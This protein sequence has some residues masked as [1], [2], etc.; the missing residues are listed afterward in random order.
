[1]SLFSNPV[2]DTP[3]YS[4]KYEVTYT[5]L[6]NFPDSTASITVTH[7]LGHTNYLVTFSLDNT[8]KNVAIQNRTSTTFDVVLDSAPALGAVVNVE[9]VVIEVK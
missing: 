3:H 4:P 1:M 5:E 8:G 7:N 9:V 6:V 2:P